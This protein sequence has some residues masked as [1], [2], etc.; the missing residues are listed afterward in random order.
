MSHSLVFYKV[1][2]VTEDL[3]EIINTDNTEFPYY[4]VRTE[5]AAEWEKEIGAIRTIE[6]STVDQ[7]AACEKLFGMKPQSIGTS[8]EYYLR[9]DS[10]WAELELSF[11]DGEKRYVH[12]TEM[13]KFRKNVQYMA[14]VYIREE[15]ARIETGYK[16]ESEAYEDKPLSEQDILEIAKQYLND[17]CDEGGGYA[18]EPDPMVVIMKAYFSAVDGY[19]IVCESV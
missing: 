5:K 3:P 15:I 16:V 17:Y 13:E 4:Y 14:C 12:R 1:S 8:P 2:R 18:Y 6:Y 7:F 10:P 11:P 19:C 9:P